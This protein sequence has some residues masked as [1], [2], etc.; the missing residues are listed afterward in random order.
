MRGEQRGKGRGSRGGGSGGREGGRGREGGG[1]ARRGRGGGG[2]GSGRQGEGTAAAGG[3]GGGG[4]GER[5]REKEGACGKIRWREGTGRGCV[6]R[7][8]L[9]RLVF[10]TKTKRSLV[11]LAVTT[12][13]KAPLSVPDLKSTGTKR[14]GWKVSSLACGTTWM[15]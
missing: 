1:R 8:V 6:G 14:V 15:R 3:K 12:G 2:G 7:G 4:P 13:T 11:P 10:P 5:I 9:S